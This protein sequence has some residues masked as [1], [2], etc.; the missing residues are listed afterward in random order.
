MAQAGI[1][2]LLIGSDLRMPMLEKAFG[3]EKTPGLTD[4]LLGNYQWQK[5][6]QSVTD[7]VMGK[8]TWTQVMMTSGLDKLNIITTGSIPPN[9]ADLIESKRLMDFVE[10]VK[11]EFDLIIFDSTPILSAADAAILGTKV[12]GVLLVYRLG[13]VSRGLLKRSTTQLRQVNCNIMGVI[14]NGMKPEVSP[15]FHQ[16]KYYKYHYS[17]GKGPKYKRDQKPKKGFSFFRKT[18]GGKE[19]GRQKVLAKKLQKGPT[20]QENK[21]H[22][23][24]LTLMWVAFAFLGV[25]I[26]LQHGLWGAFKGVELK[27]PVKEK[28]IK[29][30]VKKRIS[31][32]AGT[33]KVEAISVR[34]EAKSSSEKA[35]IGAET[36]SPPTPPVA[37]I[38]VKIETPASSEKASS[39]P[40]SIQLGSFHTLKR[41][42]K[43]IS[44]YSKKGL[45]PY[46]VKV[47]LSKGIW[48]RVFTGHF[49]DREQA[50]RF[51]LEH[52]VTEAEVKKTEYANLIGNYSDADELEKQ[53]KSL[54][55][56]GYS[57][58]VIK[59]RD[60]RS[61]VF[62]GAFFPKRRAERQ[63]HDLKS[64]GIQSQVVKRKYFP[65]HP[66]SLAF[67]YYGSWI[68]RIPPKTG[69]T[70]LKARMFFQFY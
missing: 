8:M 49:E 33:E 53:I 48:Y 15:D 64:S 32:P 60:G 67:V 29:N 39:H 11:K 22:K 40:Y 7:V 34:P 54:K 20:E 26:L 3:L 27:K 63:Y 47:E 23:A 38:R 55:N 65:R 13:K 18:E 66:L 14:L 19:A 10:E 69:M 44:I 57:P 46:W 70:N 41:A 31:K 24:K 37:K 17:Y 12:D 35:W 36:L 62:I 68:T 6:V 56:H 4:I 43:A 61:R 25:G 51:R 50:E 28:T 16:D 45:S 52:G 21:H 2:T 42:K 58:Y 5:T 30:S 59:D 9:P 1:K